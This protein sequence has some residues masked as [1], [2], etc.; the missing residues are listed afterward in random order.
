MYPRLASYTLRFYAAIAA[1][2][3]FVSDAHGQI[4]NRAPASAQSYAALDGAFTALKKKDYDSA[5]AGF[6]RVLERIPSRNDVRKNLAYAYFKVG[7]NELA[8]REFAEIVRRDTTDE[9]AALE[10]AFLDFES[11]ES[12]RKADAYQLFK[13]LRAARDSG[14]RSRSAAAFAS[15]DTSLSI[16]M[17]RWMQAMRKEPDNDIF[18][19]EFA[20]AAEERGLQHLA[21]EYYRG[22][23]SNPYS[24]LWLDVARL[25]RA[26]GRPRDAEEIEQRAAKGDNPFL[27]EQVREEAAIRRGNAPRLEFPPL[28]KVRAP[29]SGYAILGKTTGSSW[30]AVL[31]AGGFTSAEESSARLIVL[32]SDATTKLVDPVA[33]VRNGMF[34]ILEDSSATAEAFGFRF[35][36]DSTDARVELDVHSKEQ[37][38]L[39]KSQ[40]RLPGVALPA[41]AIVF[42]RERWTGAPLLAGFRLGKGGVL[43]VA[44]SP[45]PKGFERFPYFLLALADLGMAPAVRGKE[46]QVLLD[47]SYR[48]RAD[49]DYLAKQWRKMGVGTVH[50]SAWYFFDR[51]PERDR[52]VRSLIDAAHIQGI[53]VYAWFE[54]P[55]VS[56]KFWAS[57]PEWREKN[58]LL[59]DAE[60]FW[61]KNIN[62]GNPEAFRAVAAGLTE[63][64]MQFDWDGAN[65]SELYFEGPLGLKNLAEFTPLNQDVRQEVAAEY[66]FD[67]ANLFDLGSPRYYSRNPTGLKQYQDYRVALQFRLHVKFLDVLTEVRRRKGGSFGI[68]VIYLDDIFEPTMRE[69]IGAD[70]R[71]VLALIPKYD[72]TF[73]L[74]DAAILWGLGP[75]RYARMADQYAAI[76]DLKNKLSVDVNIVA[77]PEVVFPTNQQTGTEFLQLVNVAERSFRTV[78]LYAENSILDADIPLLSS[79]SASAVSVKIDVASRVMRRARVLRLHHGLDSIAQRSSVPNCAPAHSIALACAP[80]R[81]GRRRAARGGARYHGPRADPQA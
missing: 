12:G 9:S 65:L 16:R 70:A 5:I 80:A 52:Y 64:L 71:K 51:D 73:V 8:R 21:E 42:S 34:L 23:T 35:S 31:G 33:E 50:V 29:A 77:R 62:L 38:I 63:M 57:H 32:P 46:I 22:S 79:A 18:S 24:V 6:L 39:W 59:Q 78:M 47:W 17:E 68:A 69:L 28:V 4:A 13:R 10:L 67:P 55:H 15:V 60:I 61:R 14:V 3:V 53:V 56:D 11:R 72:F 20:R 43:W 75:D 25:L 1:I 19:W 58:A 81:V 45:G 7:K 36:K 66:G 49:P 37:T 2:C 40:L 30:P 76:T 26:Q 44:T 54:F 27:A 41:Q 74:E 48:T